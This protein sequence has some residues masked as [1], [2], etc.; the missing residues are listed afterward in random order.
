M[1]ESYFV[2]GLLYFFFLLQILRMMFEMLYKES[3]DVISGLLPFY[4]LPL[5]FAIITP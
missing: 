4:I 3:K 5:I 1:K 2:R